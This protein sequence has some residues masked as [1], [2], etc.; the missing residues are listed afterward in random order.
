LE[1]N[2]CGRFKVGG[3]FEDRQV[4]YSKIKAATWRPFAVSELSNRRTNLEHA[5]FSLFT[6]L[7]AKTEAKIGLAPLLGGSVRRRKQQT[8]AKR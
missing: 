5:I 6:Q 2:E 8:T 4:A 7:A 1:K 3:I